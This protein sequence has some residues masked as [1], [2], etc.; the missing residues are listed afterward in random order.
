MTGKNFTVDAVWDP[1]AKVWYS[2]SDIIGLHIEAETFED[3][4]KE[5]HEHAAYL[6]VANHYED[7]EIDRADLKN[8]IP[9][10]FLRTVNGGPS[11]A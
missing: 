5:V 11:A 4:Q 6:V 3:F 1:E 2:E 10:I 9:A 8:L 7:S